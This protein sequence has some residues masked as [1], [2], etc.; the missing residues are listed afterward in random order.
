MSA[1]DNTSVLKDE[2]DLFLSIVGKPKVYHIRKKGDN[3][4]R[5]IFGLDNPNG[6]FCYKEFR[7]GSDT[8]KF[9]TYNKV[10]N[11]DIGNS[12]LSNPK[13]S[14][15]ITLKLNSTDFYFNEIDTTF[16]SNGLHF[17]TNTGKNTIPLVDCLSL[18]DCNRKLY[19]SNS[20]ASK[21]SEIKAL[22]DMFTFP[23]NSVPQP[24]QQKCTSFK[25]LPFLDRN[26]LSIAKLRLNKENSDYNSTKKDKA[27]DVVLEK[28]NLVEENTLNPTYKKLF[29]VCRASLP[30]NKQNTRGS[31]MLCTSPSS[32]TRPSTT[33][34]SSKK[35]TK[36]T[37]KLLVGNRTYCV[38]LGV[39]GGRYIK[40][41]GEMKP[42][43]RL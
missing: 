9:A 38:Y 14:S 2:V 33:G 23:T 3:T 31:Y 16:D 15:S 36:S 12:I 25:D 8:P 35:Y 6:T 43:R 13:A 20:Y 40:V 29:D 18:V 37:E 17:E 41:K 19:A 34:G 21:S 1:S 26:D 42:V 24:K 11:V 28:L 7:V 10:H 30:D 5:Y 27:C 39:R 4:G 32:P 22:I